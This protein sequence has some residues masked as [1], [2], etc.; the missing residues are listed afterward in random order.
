MFFL[1][2]TMTCMMGDGL[3]EGNSWHEW[4]R[5]EREKKQDEEGGK[6]ESFFN[7]QNG[8]LFLI[9]PVSAFSLRKTKQAFV[10]ISV[11]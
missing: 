6:I 9:Y 2:Q 8:P 7:L 4:E 11:I 3:R 1:Q 5:S 10:I